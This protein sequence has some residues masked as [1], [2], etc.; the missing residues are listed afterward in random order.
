MYGITKWVLL[1]LLL[2]VGYVARTQT[3]Q[4]DVKTLAFPANGT[5]QCYPVTDYTLPFSDLTNCYILIG[6]TKQA[7]IIDPADELEPVVDKTTGRATKKLLMDKETGEAK[8][9]TIE[10]LAKYTVLKTD[11]G[12]APTVVKDLDTGREKFVY[13][14][15]RTTEI[16]G[17]KIYKYLTDNKI[18]VKLIVISHGHL[19]HFGAL[20]YLQ[21]K[22]GAKVLMH[23]SDLRG[24]NGAKLKAVDGVMPAGYP[25]DSYRIIGLSTK[26]DQVLKDGDIISLDG[27]VLQVMHTPGHSPGSISLHTRKGAQDILFSGDTLLHWY[28]LHD[29]NGD[30][31]RDEQGNPVYADYGRTNFIDGSGDENLLF[32]SIRDK[33]FTLP[34]DTIVYPEHNTDAEH[35]TQITNNGLATAFGISTIEDEKK[36]SPATHYVAPEEKKDAN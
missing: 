21:Q 16:F 22:T 34:D 17:K 7:I 26:V 30:V 32:K 33:L 29:Y 14:Q 10:D 25:K 2:A 4:P 15:F 8:L 35:P 28:N 36:H 5:I 11:F 18:Q 19:D 6:K 24:L 13:D 23:G 12:G 1:L 31:L 27:M 9:V 3:P 20:T